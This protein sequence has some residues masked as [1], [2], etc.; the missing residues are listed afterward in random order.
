[1]WEPTRRENG[2]GRCHWGTGGHTPRSNA[3]QWSHRGIGDGM[4]AHGDPTQ[5][6]KPRA[7]EARDLQPDAREGQAGPGGVADRPAVPPTPGNAGRG[8]GPE[9]KTDARR[10]TRAGRLAM[11]L[12]PPPKVQKLQEALHA[13]AKGSPTYRFYALYDKVYRRDVLEWAYVRSRANDGAP[14][15]PPALQSS[16]RHGSETPPARAAVDLSAGPGTEIKAGRAQPCYAPRSTHRR[17]ALRG[18][19]TNRPT[20]V[21]D[22]PHA[23][24]LLAGPVPVD[25]HVP[26]PLD[27]DHF[28]TYLAADPLGALDDPLTDRHHLLDH[29]PLLH[30]DLL[31]ANRDADLL[32]GLARRGMPLDDHL[33]ALHRDLDRA[34]LG[35]DLLADADLARRDELLVGMQLLG[36]E[37][38][39]GALA[40]AG[41]RGVRGRV[42]VPVAMMARAGRGLG[43]PRCGLGD[44]RRGLSGAG[45]R[46]VLGV[47][48]LAVFVIHR[49][50][51][52][53]TRIPR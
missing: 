41:G 38:D 15:V 21:A 24:S 34:V 3:N 50:A 25:V 45:P 43:E 2:E 19:L 51:A 4:S 42:R 39:R 28:L 5:H 46:L 13:K 35:D 12:P 1:M 52:F 23:L 30:G 26:L 8:K 40:R 18:S 49:A 11:S 36:V 17:S 14:G 6:G 9:F 10:G 48:H 27:A 7:V 22:H 53:R 33:L 16:R 29:R 44:P 20:R 47:Q 31:L 32:D 37:L